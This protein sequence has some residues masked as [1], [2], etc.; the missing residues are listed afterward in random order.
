MNDIYSTY[1]IKCKKYKAEDLTKEL[2]VTLYEEAVHE[3]MTMDYVNSCGL[4][5]SE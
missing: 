3:A 5:A 4:N 2:K 1:L